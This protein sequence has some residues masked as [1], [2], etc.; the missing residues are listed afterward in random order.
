M[1][2]QHLNLE[3][4]YYTLFKENGIDLEGF[5]KLTEKELNEIGVK[6][7]KLITKKFLKA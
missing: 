4:K 5:L 2:F 1:L 6:V 7:T 3:N